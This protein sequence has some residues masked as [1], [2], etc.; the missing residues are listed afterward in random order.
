VLFVGD[1]AELEALADTVVDSGLPVAPAALHG[2]VC[3]FAV[4]PAEDFPY[5]ELTDLLD[6]GLAGDDPALVRFVEEVREDLG[7]EDLGFTLLLP[8][9]DAPLEDRVTALG[10]WCGHFLEAFGTGLARLPDDDPEYGGFALPDELQ[11]I[12]DDLAAIA[13]VEPDADADPEDA[14][15]QYMELEEFVKVAVLLI[16]SVLARGRDDQDF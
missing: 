8:D 7:R 4:F 9:D 13:D 10:L 11:E 12:V 16:M 15:S 3:G 1:L 2:A 14:E 6:P 5:W